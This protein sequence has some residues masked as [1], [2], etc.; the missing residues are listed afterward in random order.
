MKEVARATGPS[1]VD[2]MKALK[3]KPSDSFPLEPRVN[4][5]DKLSME[6]QIPQEGK[7]KEMVPVNVKVSASPI[8]SR[9]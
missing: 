1:V 7:T 3:I 6:A 2:V 4:D 9:G 8:K 5:K